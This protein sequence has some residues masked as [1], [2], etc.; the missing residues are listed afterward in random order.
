[1]TDLQDSLFL[2]ACRGLPTERTPIW[3]MRQAGRYMP[4]YR[5]IRQKHSML[6]CISTPELAAEITLQPID[7]FGFDAAIMF[8][9]ILPPLQTMGLNLE[10]IK[11]VG[12][13]IHN[14]VTTPYD[15]DLLATPPAEDAMEGTLEAIGLVAAELTPRGV[16]LIGFC[17]APFT[18]ASYA[19]EGGGSKNY[20]KT[21]A[22]MYAEP[23]AWIRLMDKLTTVMAD[24][25]VKQARAGASALQIF[26]SW[27]GL[28]LN[29]YD[30]GRYVKP[31]NA[32]LMRMVR[33]QVS[34]PVIYFSTGTSEYLDAI[35]EMEP[36]VI[37]VDWRIS[38]GEAWNR[39]GSHHPLMGNLDPV[40]LLAPWRE[41]RF[42]IDQ[43]LEEA[44]GRPGYVFNLG[45]GIFKNT[46][47]ENV[48][49]AVA[50]VREATSQP[51]ET[52]A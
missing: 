50:Y 41:L 4:E 46:P 47:V 11:G 43:V 8:S 22:L 35:A 19:I 15:I 16:P 48:E 17:G 6:Q 45:H 40:A 25:L 24:Y 23:A 49:R 31:F 44:Q 28:A 51:K 2:R 27:A 29:R 38:L 7:A 42:R 52:A 30:Y 12:P 3:F 26:D 18:L 37:G 36:D 9:D 34:V 20:D 5:A 33:Q 1:M 10:F 39:V 14:P 13:V 21:K 32:K